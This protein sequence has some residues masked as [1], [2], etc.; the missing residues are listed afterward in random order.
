MKDLNATT[1]KILSIFDDGNY[2]DGSSIG[3]KLNISRAAVWKH[4]QQLQTLG[5]EFTSTKG[6]GYCLQKPIIL[7]D[8]KRIE[9]AIHQNFSNT[10][11]Y[12]T[13]H[14]V[15]TNEYLKEQH[16]DSNFNF[17]IAEQQTKGKGRFDRIWHSPF[18]Q[19]IYF[20]VKHQTLQDISKLSGLSLAVAVAIIH[21]LK[22]IGINADI[23]WPN[24]ILYQ[25]KKLAGIL[26]EV[27]AQPNTQTN[28]IIGI[29]LNVNM[30]T[31]QENISS[32]WIS[33][34]QILQK[35]F[36]RNALIEILCKE[37][38]DMITEF[39]HSGIKNYLDLYHKHHFLTDKH[40]SLQAG[41]M[42]YTGKVI[43]ISELGYLKL[44]LPNGE[45]KNFSS[46]EVTIDKNSL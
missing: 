43:G 11:V 23:K 28:I 41:K 16:D 6:K 31:D 12:V 34:S 33:I 24:D 44:L 45:I 19:N 26:I 8:K 25:K 2:H 37:L 1:K 42:K 5:I 13:D 39:E 14:I 10:T 7:L 18:A 46:G 15:S 29:G 32:D 35:Q 36:D 17:C 30:E 3:Q 21:I 40:I 9:Q 4:I 27:T 38:S 22:K 20:S